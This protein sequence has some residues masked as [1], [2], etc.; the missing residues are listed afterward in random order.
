MEKIKTFINNHISFKFDIAT[1]ASFITALLIV[2]TVMFLPERC[3]FEN[4]KV[5]YKM[6]H[7]L[8]WS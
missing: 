4:E 7:P 3:G 2:P 8:M 1:T 5:R 6:L